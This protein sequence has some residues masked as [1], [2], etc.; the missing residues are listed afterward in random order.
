MV[1]RRVVLTAAMTLLAIAGAR[2]TPQ[3]RS[4]STQPPTFR[5]QTTVVVQN[6]IAR[7]SQGRVVEGLT[8]GDFTVLENGQPQEI[9]F[10]SFQSLSPVPGGPI[11]QQRIEP[12]LPLDPAARA[13]VSRI[14]IP[15]RDDTTY[16]DRRL[17][18]M[19]FDL[20]RMAQGDRARAFRDAA[21]FVQTRMTASDVI[22]VMGV[23]DGV[24]RVRQDFTADRPRLLEVLT[25]MMNGD[26]F[27]GDGTPDLDSIGSD[28]GQNDGEFNAFHTD[29]RF[30]ALQSAI[31]M[32]Q[33][34]P[35]QKAL[36]YFASGLTAA[37]VDNAAQYLAV[38]NSAVRANVSINPID[39]RGLVALSPIGGASRP[40]PDGMSVFTGEAAE[41]S[42]R[43]FLAS[44]DTLYSL[45]KDTGG[46]AM[47]DSNDL[48]DGIAQAAATLPGYY[49]VGYYSVNTAVDGAFRR[50]QVRLTGNRRAD[51][52]QRPGYYA[53]K[54]WPRLTEAEREQRL[55]EAFRLENPVTDIPLSVEVDYFKLNGS[56]YYV[57]V[58]AKLPGGELTLLRNR[59]AATTEIDF[60]TEVKDD[61]R[62]THSNVRDRL[63]LRLVEPS[64]RLPQQ[65]IHYQTG[66]T[67]L[68]GNYVLKL[69][70]RDLVTGR[71]GTFQARFTI[72]NLDNDADAL[73]ISTVV[74]SNQRVP[75]GS[76][77]AAVKNSAAEA[78]D[79]LI[80][81]K[82]R[83]LPSVTR[84]FNR[85]RPF[86]VY[87]QAYQPHASTATPVAAYVTFFR[88]GEKIYT[89]RVVQR[90]WTTPDSRA[91]PIRFA[92]SI[93]HLPPGEYDCQ[94]TVVDPGSQKA[95][96]WRAPIVVA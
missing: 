64:A 2:A 54:A 7:D 81:Q 61:H 50:V 60:Y 62:V 40:S 85:Y 8:A 72:P 37:S 24:L 66:F 3:E 93:A 75:L 95:A 87:L 79:P 39:V 1:N 5:G 6:V 18:V 25:A 59:G 47:V 52:A 69:L 82:Q 41:N 23:R 20:S 9:A 19:Y 91:V 96:F 51:L 53:D 43:G 55:S 35:Q 67:L 10:V 48:A 68:P 73:P 71:I 56:E 34:M 4:T 30:A 32:L 88:N 31:S 46:K 86:I 14:H 13:A 36:L 63:P 77:L 45:A 76:E 92:L 29:R 33:P 27:D 78:V 21:A 16:D 90:D 94:V 11:L 58:T 15:A 38:V 42:M 49:M 22:A 74:L 17:L 65:P 84:V 57:P 83:L 80:E 28:F 44:Q 26:D 12:A 89:A 70:A